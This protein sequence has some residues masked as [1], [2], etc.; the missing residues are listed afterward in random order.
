[1]TAS[2]HRQSGPAAPRGRQLSRGRLI[3]AIV[4]IA[5]TVFGAAAASVF[6]VDMATGDLVF[7]AVS[8]EGEGDLIGRRFPAGTG[9]A[10]WVAAYG[11]PLLVDDTTDSPQ[12][13]RGAAAST[14]YVPRSI[15]AAPLIAAGECLGVVEV[16]DRGSRLRGELGDVDLL[17][18]LATELGTAL[19]LLYAGSPG[20]GTA[21]GEDDPASS[22][23]AQLLQRVAGRLPE[24]AEP[25]AST[26]RSLLA[27]A[28]DLLARDGVPVGQARG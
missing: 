10:G 2:D 28:D 13:A 23:D 12:F 8:G 22:S 27:M 3:Q 7:E 9:I 16:L 20:T 24:A 14:G 26:A 5:R 6:L 21:L 25:V 17:G 18:M 4:E 11:Q 1:M 19:E 15:M